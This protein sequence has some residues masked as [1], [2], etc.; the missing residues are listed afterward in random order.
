MA[1]IGNSLL[2]GLFVE[3][4][5]LK[6]VDASEITSLNS[7]PDLKDHCHVIQVGNTTSAC[8]CL[9][10]SLELHTY[11]TYRNEQDE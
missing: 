8:S 2:S 11:S 1:Y 5:E 3:E 6:H 7:S 4:E 9:S 10:C